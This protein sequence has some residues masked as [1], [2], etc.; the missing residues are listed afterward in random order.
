MKQYRNFSL[1]TIILI[2]WSLVVEAQT[3][4]RKLLTW[5][6]KTVQ[7]GAVLEEN[8]PV[9]AVFRATNLNDDRIFITDVITDCGCTT[10]DYTKDTLGNTQ[11]ANIQV[12]FDPDHRGGEFSKVIIVRTNQDIYGD[13]LFLEGVNMP[14]PEN[15]EMAYPYRI[16][17]V[18]FRLPGINMGNVF[19]NEPKIRYVEVHN[20]GSG[21]LSLSSLQPQVPEYLNFQLEPEQIPS[22]KRG[23]MVVKYDGQKKHDLGFFDESVKVNLKEGEILD[24]RILSVVY[25]YFSPVPKSMEN[26]VPRIFISENEVD[27]REVPSGRKVHRSLTVSNRGQEDLVIR[28][29]MGNCDC[30]KLNLSNQLI[31]PGER[32]NLDFEFDTKG[33]KGIDHK[34]IT[35][36]SNDPIN[37]VRT[38]TIKSSIK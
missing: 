15:V 38:I 6:Q 30:L 7:I 17:K 3:L 10:V 20:F 37:P 31:R 21:V 8:G 4:E 12:R 22:G 35:I 5:D 9:E 24:L 19:T 34:H 25:E 18:G 29:I 26:T 32:V 2:S 23:V 11:K 16:G 13:T 14:V 1:F 33:R 28:K 27:F 36:F